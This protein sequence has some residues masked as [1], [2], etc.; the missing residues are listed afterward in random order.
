MALE[1]LIVIAPAIFPTGDIAKNKKSPSKIFAGIRSSRHRLAP[2]AG[3][4]EPYALFACFVRW[5][6]RSRAK[7]SEVRFR[8][9]A[10][11]AFFARADRCA[12]VIFCAAF[13]P[14]CLPYSRAIS[15]IAAR[16][17]EGILISRSYT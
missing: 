15:F 13:F 10:S 5:A 16:T 4:F 14:P 2:P 7:R 9:A 8:A 11:D 6:A 3:Q 17:S 12:G 1:K